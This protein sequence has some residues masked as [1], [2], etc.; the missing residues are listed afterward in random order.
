MK[1]ST[2]SCRT[3]LRPPPRPDR[4]LAIALAC[5]LL[6]STACVSTGAHQEVVDDRDRLASE[7][8]LARNRITRLEAS[9]E[10]L[11]QERVALADEVEDLRIARA[12]LESS[13]AELSASGERLASNLEVRET[14]LAARSA[15]VN[16]LRATYDGLV[17]DLQ[18]EVAEGR[19]EIEQL[20]E[21]LSVRLSQAILF[22]SGSARLSAEGREVLRTVAA[23]LASLPHFVDVKGHTDDIPIRGTLA[24]RY[25]SNWELAGARAASVVRLLE[26][27]GIGSDRLSATSRAATRPVASNDTDEGR[28]KNRRIEILL[29]PQEQSGAPEPARDSEDQEATQSSDGDALRAGA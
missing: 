24:Q 10:S 23:R 16:E 18:S 14:E 12:E 28:A 25:P 13:V 11:D 15:E 5:T 20:R 6:A 19:I 4:S 21:G 9:S 2:V 29:R 22:P 7:L 26:D 8:A 27:A 1:P 3:R 17:D